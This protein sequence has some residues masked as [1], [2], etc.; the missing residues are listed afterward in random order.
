M[1]KS[2]KGTH[3]LIFYEINLL[4]KKPTIAFCL[5]HEETTVP[6]QNETGTQNNYR[7]HLSYTKCIS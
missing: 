4:K 7:T 5:D 6:A 2:Q 3:D 1:A